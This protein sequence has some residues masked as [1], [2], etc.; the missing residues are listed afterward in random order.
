M[1]FLGSLVLAIEVERAGVTIDTVELFAELG[2]LQDTVAQMAAGTDDEHGSRVGQIGLVARGSEDG[3]ELAIGELRVAG[4]HHQERDSVDK[5]RDR[6][7]P[8]ELE[9]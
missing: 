8:D 6:D 5:D 4:H 9:R 2:R 3:D 1:S 7:L